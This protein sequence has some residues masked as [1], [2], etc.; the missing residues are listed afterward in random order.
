MPSP[1]L[2]GYKA[3]YPP[4]RY[5]VD[6]SVKRRTTW[7]NSLT[8]TS[9][10]VPAG[11]SDSDNL[12]MF[13]VAKDGGALRGVLP[14]AGI[15][16][17]WTLIKDISGPQ[18]VNGPRILAYWSEYS[19]DMVPFTLV[20]MNANGNVIQTVLRGGWIV[21]LAGYSEGQ[22]AGT[23]GAYTSTTPDSLIWG[24]ITSQKSYGTTYSDGTNIGVAS[25]AELRQRV[26]LDLVQHESFV[27]HAYADGVFNGV[28][29]DVRENAVYDGTYLWF[30]FAAG[31]VAVNPATFEIVKSTPSTNIDALAPSITASFQ[32]PSIVVD[33]VNQQLWRVTQAGTSSFGSSP[34]A[35]ELW[36]ISTQPATFVARN[37]YTN[38]PEGV[39][40]F[41]QADPADDHVLLIERLD[42]T[43]PS[44]PVTVREYDS[45]NMLVRAWVM[46]GV[47]N[48][49]NAWVMYEAGVPYLF[50]DNG[51]LRKL[52][53]LTLAPSGPIVANTGGNPGDSLYAFG[54]LWFSSR[55]DNWVKR[56]NPV[57]M[58]LTQQ[59]TV[60][61]YPYH[62]AATS[63]SVFVSTDPNLNNSG[64]ANYWSNKLRRI[65][66]TT[67]TVVNIYNTFVGR[68]LASTDNFLCQ[69]EGSRI[70][71]I[72]T[73]TGL[74]GL[75]LDADNYEFYPAYSL[76]DRQ[77]GTPYVGTGPRWRKFPTQIPSA[78]AAAFISLNGEPIDGGGWTLG[79]MGV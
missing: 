67:N 43:S 2:I 57:T 52:N 44:V 68:M 73:T 4:A 29:L 70:G 79:M 25:A 46:T 33:V 71:Q 22:Y 56:V 7:A 34:N 11:L 48:M 65:D 21:V 20:P 18:S 51:N 47:A 8:I 19:P 75:E 54:S 16:P 14:F 40:R 1:E 58:T 72:D 59:I 62:L 42:Y 6:G 27:E 60:P 24:N 63:T 66:P 53:L 30:N 31:F 17:Q 41:P 28:G 32:Q 36:D 10:D 13:I 9:A 55:F 26:N 12:L 23:G 69:V 61:N 64:Q 15:G 3:I 76:I 35:L 50:T 38:P 74:A 49:N 78:A 39:V 77:F 5:F 45:N 37:T